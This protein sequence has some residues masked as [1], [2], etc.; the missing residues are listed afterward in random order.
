M[1]RIP[2][3]SMAQAFVDSKIQPGKVVVFIKPTCPFCK[4]AQEILSQLPFKQGFLEFVD[5]TTANDMDGIQ[6]YFQRLTGARTVSVALCSELPP[7][8]RWLFLPPQHFSPRQ[9]GLFP[10][11]GPEGFAGVGGGGSGLWKN[12]LAIWEVQPACHATAGLQCPS[13]SREALSSVPWVSGWM[14]G[15]QLSAGP[16]GGTGRCVEGLGVGTPLPFCHPTWKSKAL[17]A[18]AA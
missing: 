11:R 3:I 8:T 17:P 12:R 7:T 6:D 1:E 14:R 2:P 10:L 18:L 4:R 5:I 13:C 16:P 9:P 15:S